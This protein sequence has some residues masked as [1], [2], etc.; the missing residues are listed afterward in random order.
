[1]SHRQRRH[2]LHFCALSGAVAVGVAFGSGYFGRPAESTVILALPQPKNPVTYDLGRALP[3]S[4]AKIDLAPRHGT[5]TAISLPAKLTLPVEIDLP[6]W[7]RNAVAVAPSRGRPQIAVIMDDAGVNRRNTERAIAL[8]AP[9]TISFLPYAND[10]EPLVRQA[11]VKGHEIMVHLP[12]EPVG[13]EKDP[14]PHALWVDEDAAQILQRLDWNLARFDGYVGVNNHMGSRFSADRPAMRTVL[15]E[16]HRRGLLFID[17]RTSGSSVGTDVA[18]HLGMPYG[19]RDVFLDN[20]E[21]PAAIR[22]QL[23][24]LENIARARGQAVAIGHPYDSTIAALRDW[25]A[26]VPNRGFE[27]VPVSRI[28]ERDVRERAVAVAAAQ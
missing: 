17:S 18:R 4:G 24:T 23:D 15:T 26:D 13:G 9:L 2:F 25:L 8:E 19:E 11:R 10:L 22:A 5:V 21:D 27:L 6:Q 1:M 7:K 14:G 28:V 16:L 20:N 3:G 12:M